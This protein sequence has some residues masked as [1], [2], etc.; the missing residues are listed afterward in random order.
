MTP[1][2]LKAAGYVVST[3]SV[4]LLGVAAWPGA[5][6]AGLLGALVAGMAASVVG[7]GLRWLSYRKESRERRHDGADRP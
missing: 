7:M 6:E 5:K 2:A 4:G 1:P 3:I